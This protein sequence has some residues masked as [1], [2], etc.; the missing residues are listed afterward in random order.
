MS[1]RSCL[2]DK[3]SRLANLESAKS[4]TEPLKAMVGMPRAGSLKINF[5]L[6]TE[7]QLQKYCMDFVD[8]N[9]VNDFNPRL[10]IFQKICEQ[11]L[12]SVKV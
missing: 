11:I 8:D 9:L 1:D 2:S 10:Q 7:D 12:L 5:V 6:L 4:G 3:H